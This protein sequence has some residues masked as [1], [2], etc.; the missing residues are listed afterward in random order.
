M[1]VQEFEAALDRHGADLARWPEALRAGAADLLREDAEAA[2]LLAAAE[3]VA[4]LLGEAVEPIPVDAA[5]VGRII[6]GVQVPG[7]TEGE[8]RLRP[9]RRLVAFASAAMLIALTIGFTAGYLI[10]TDEGDDAVAA[11]VFGDDLDIGAL[12]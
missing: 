6:A 4:H 7:R 11:L 2:R 5:L 10:P 3:R 8:L 9:T 1:N 12:L